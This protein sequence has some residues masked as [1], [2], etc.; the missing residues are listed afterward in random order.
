[1]AQSLSSFFLFS[2][3]SAAV[4]RYKLGARC[5]S[6]A[7]Y[8]KFNYVNGKW[9]NEEKKTQVEWI[10]FVLRIKKKSLIDLILQN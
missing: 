2:F 5:K 4:T 7:T 6:I 1:M 10:E 3:V 8:C 9:C